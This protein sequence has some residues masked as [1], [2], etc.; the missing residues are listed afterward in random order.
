[1]KT[2]IINTIN[3]V[4]LIILIIF[5]D[6]A[7]LRVVS[8]I[9]V[10]KEERKVTIN[11]TGLA[12]SVDKVYNSVVV[13]HVENKTSSGF[14]SGFVYKID[15]K[16]AYILTNHHVI[17][18]AEDVSV[19]FMNDVELE[20][21]VVGSDEYADIAV[22][23]INKTD[24]MQAAII[25]N[26]D[27][28][29][30]GD[31]IFTIGTPVNVRY[32]GTVTRGIVSGKDRLVTISV[33]GAY[34]DDYIMKAIQIDAPINSGNSGG[35]LCNANGE[36]IGINTMKIASETTENIGFSIPIEDAIMYASE[37]I[38][39]GKV[40]RPY[41][42]VSMYDLDTAK[43]IAGNDIRVDDDIEG[44]YIVDAKKG[45]P[46]Y[47]SGMRSGDI[48][49]KIGD[50]SISNVSEFKYTLYKY[51]PNSKVKMTVIRNNRVHVFTVTLGL[52]D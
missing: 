11:D 51:K 14:G 43:Y 45:S 5:I 37:I 52:S 31:T 22:L 10:Q 41:L 19:E 7:V 40:E 48:L 17:E 38:E 35:P 2:K 42:G 27:N 33:S 21:K 30:L 8:V 18:K 20:A 50:D 47:A 3:L 29:R 16:K 34:T 25:G 23:S 39:K 36:V 32:K 6:I 49:T 9:P 1:M 4:S 28:I 12:E 24:E 44:I 15:G 13:V 46:A 26:S